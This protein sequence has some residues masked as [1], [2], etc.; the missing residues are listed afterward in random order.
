[1]RGA[2]RACYGGLVQTLK[3]RERLA[4]MAEHLA[5]LERLPREQVNELR[6]STP[7]WVSESHRARDMYFEAVRRG[8]LLGPA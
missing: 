5:A 8:W 2:A 1:M 6:A 7:P 4:R 3:Q